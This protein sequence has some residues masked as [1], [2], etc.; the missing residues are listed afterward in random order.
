LERLEAL[1]TQ[2]KFAT[3]R[4]H[5]ERDFQ[6][7]ASE[8]LEISAEVHDDNLLLIVDG[9]TAQEAPRFPEA[10][11]R[12]GQVCIFG[13]GESFDQNPPKAVLADLSE[14]LTEEDRFLFALTP[15]F[16]LG[17]AFCHGDHRRHAPMGNW[18]GV[19]SQVRAA[20]TTLLQLSESTSDVA[21][22]GGESSSDP[23]RDS[24]STFRIVAKQSTRPSTGTAGSALDRNDLA[25][26]L[27]ILKSLSAKRR[28]H[29]ILYVFVEQIASVVDIDR[30]SVVQ[31]WEDG[32]EGHVLASHEDEAISDLKIDLAKYPE[33]GA[34]LS[35]RR[36]VLS[37]DVGSDSLMAP[38]AA[39]LSKA[40][41]TAI[42][43]IP[44]VLYDQNVGSFFLRAALRGRA[45]T[46]R[47]VGFCEIVGEAAANALERAHLLDSIQRANQHLERLAITDGLTGVYNH[48]YFR[49]RLQD[50]YERAARYALPLACMLVDVDDFKSINDTF[51]H[52]Q[53]DKVLVEIA[54]RMMGAVR[55][56][57]IVARYG[58][59]EFVVLLPQTPLEGAVLQAN[60]LLDA[61]SSKHYDGL[62]EGAEVTVSIGMTV[63][64][65]DTMKESSVLVAVA[66]AALYQAKNS[67]KNQVIIKEN[68]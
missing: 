28:T 34:A 42:L 44:I 64:D 65:P 6:T 38:F 37:N 21:L 63:L 56:N 30:C 26:V 55:S 43:V 62:P 36:K 49:D 61:I 10:L 8:I 3:A 18:L 15:C 33:I 23:E 4:I 57:D 45:F 29:D 58:G 32:L 25:S 60:R 2:K 5:S 46:D 47:D 12:A 39:D 59:E 50:E 52:Q 16:A 13:Q 27:E 54:S 19:R 68:L 24:E 22:P 41:I 40:G 51:G 31:V 20:A 14:P 9:I 7:V 1:T 48:R 11:A 67:G 35:R 17:V 53:G 66:D